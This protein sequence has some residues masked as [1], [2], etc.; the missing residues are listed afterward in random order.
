MYK[1]IVNI[2]VDCQHNTDRLRCLYKYCHYIVVHDPYIHHVLV[3]FYI[4]GRRWWLVGLGNTMYICW[5]VI[6]SIIWALELSHSPEEKSV[7]FGNCA[8]SLVIIRLIKPQTC[9][10]CIS[11]LTYLLHCRY[12]VWV[13]C[14]LCIFNILCIPVSGS[15]R[16]P[17]LLLLLSIQLLVNAACWRQKPCL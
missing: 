1:G 15:H 3:Q 5:E 12:I 13:H 9:M 2:V 8:C 7:G 4:K 6:N 11:F 10:H 16:D 14:L 17:F